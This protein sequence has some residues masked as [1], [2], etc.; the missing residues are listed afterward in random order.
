MKL[1]INGE[2]QSSS[3]ETLGALVEQ[4]GMK[5]DRVAIE[6]NREIV[7]RERSRRTPAKRARSEAGTRLDSRLERNYAG[8]AA[9]HARNI[10]LSEQNCS[11]RVAISSVRSSR[12]RC[13]RL[14]VQAEA[15]TDGA[16]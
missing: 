14:F 2:I 13:A 4:L 7:P 5:P 8:S 1:T 6:L 10:L 11:D 3:A 12:G 9:V 16:P 15:R